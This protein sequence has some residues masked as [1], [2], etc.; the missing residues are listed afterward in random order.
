MFAP[1]VATVVVVFRAT[2]VVV[3]GAAVV[4]VLRATVV[5][6]AGEGWRNRELR[7][8]EYLTEVKIAPSGVILDVSDSPET[9]RLPARWVLEAAVGTPTPWTN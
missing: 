7:E 9:D 4:V 3:V 5:L 1:D 8:A 6:V 2:V